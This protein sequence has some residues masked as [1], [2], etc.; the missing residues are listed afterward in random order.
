[1][2]LRYHKRSAEPEWMDDFSIG[3]EL[4]EQTLREIATINK[5][6]G[7]NNITLSVIRE[8]LSQGDNDSYKIVDLGC[9][10]GEILRLIARWARKR[11]ITVQLIGI[12]A[13]PHVVEY[14][15]KVSKAYPEIEYRTMD[16]FSREFKLVKCDI[17]TAT[18]FTHHFSS[19]QLISL[20]KQLSQQANIGIV[21][22]DL[23]RH[24]F[25]YHSIHWI[26]RFLS[27]S[28]MVQND[29]SL[30]VLRS[31][32]KAEIVEILTKAG[33]TNFS[34]SWKWAFRW[35]LIILND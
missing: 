32:S 13:N 20:Y 12:D 2:K 17:V 9:G 8:F 35:K 3:G 27:K 22:N 4:M 29:A 34:I 5:W 6:L 30:S 23:H 11:K 28:K 1:M 31:F 19:E 26:T 25:A 21:I 16:I 24:W 14:A 33:I 10:G 7:G 18:L 15:R